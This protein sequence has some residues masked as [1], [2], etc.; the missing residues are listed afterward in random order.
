MIRRPPRS[1]LFPYTTLFRSAKIPRARPRARAHAHPR[2]R[3][4]LPDLEGHVLLEAEGRR[5]VEG[6]DGVACRPP[7]GADDGPPGKPPE[8]LRRGLGHLLRAGRVLS[9]PQVRIVGSAPGLDVVDA[10]PGRGRPD[11]AE[12]HGHGGDPRH[13]PH[14]WLLTSAPAGAL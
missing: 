2:P 13:G 4:I 9:H 5:L 8:G 7:A 10:R 1:T 11:P 6:L 3:P 14:R 12:P